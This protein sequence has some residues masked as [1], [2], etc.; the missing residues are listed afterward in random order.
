M[1]RLK[2]VYDQPTR[3]DG[4]RILV[5]RLWP[6]G[7]T[8]RRASVDLWLQAIAPSRTLRQRFSHTPDRWGEFQHAYRMEL[9]DAL[10]LLLM[11]KRFERE[12][13]VITLL[14]AARDKTRNNA[15]VVAGML[16]KTRLRRK[17]NITIRTTTRTLQQG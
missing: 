13:G 12:N 8:K 1:I 3:R 2:R 11:I 14:Y 17:D 10:G 16:R 5:D 4:L 6:R 7:L 15:V 9:K